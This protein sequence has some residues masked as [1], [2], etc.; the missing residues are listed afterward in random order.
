VKKRHLLIAIAIV[1]APF[2]ATPAA[3]AA[4]PAGAEVGGVVTLVSRNPQAAAVTARYRCQPGPED[5]WLWVSAKQAEDG[6]KDP[7]LTEEGS[8]AVAA[9]W[10]QSHPIG[11]MQCDGVKHEQVFKIN[12]DKD[13]FTGAKGFGT[14]KPGFAWVQFCLFDGQANFVSVSRWVEVH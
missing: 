8:T 9:A 11:K 5:Q 3:Q 13:P 7:A 2:A 12:T 4:S 14:L 10:Y 1:V 6:S